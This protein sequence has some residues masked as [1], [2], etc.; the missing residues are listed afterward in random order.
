M[1]GGVPYEPL[2]SGYR[3][4]VHSL[5]SLD[6]AEIYDFYVLRIF[7]CLLLGSGFVISIY[8]EFLKLLLS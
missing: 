5:R 6:S 7:C 8:L 3:P 1:Q 2:A 4:G